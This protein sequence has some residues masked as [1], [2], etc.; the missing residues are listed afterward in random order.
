MCI[1]DRNLH[2]RML[3]GI[4]QC[5]LPH[6]T[7]V[8]FQP[9]PQS[10]FDLATS[11]GYKAELTYATSW[12]WTDRKS[13]LRP[14][15]ATPANYRYKWH[16]L[17]HCVFTVFQSIIYDSDITT[18]MCCMLSLRLCI[19]CAAPNQFKCNNTGR[20]IHASDVC[21]GYNNC[22][23]WSDERTCSEQYFCLFSI[24]SYCIMT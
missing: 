19:A 16:T 7:D 17:P 9:L 1:R 10:V 15:S 12:K 13:K 6:E 5:Y 18:S 3:Y 8:T 4:T 2:T 23:D 11:E 22:G 21:N 20:C 24:M 14:V